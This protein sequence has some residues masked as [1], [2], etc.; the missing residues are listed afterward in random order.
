MKSSMDAVIAERRLTFGSGPTAKEVKVMLGK[1][2]ES[3]DKADHYCEIQILGVG[4]EKVRP[5]YG[6]DSMQ[7]LQLALRFI[8][9]QLAKYE[10]ELRWVENKDIGF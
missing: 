9:Q 3:A 4:D 5:I 1:P 7:A 8:S 10:K 2:M 6:L